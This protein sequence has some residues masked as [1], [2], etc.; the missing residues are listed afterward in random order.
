MPSASW[1][2]AEKTEIQN[3]V[4]ALWGSGPL[5]LSL[6]GQELPVEGGPVN[7]SRQG[8]VGEQGQFYLKAPANDAAA[9][10]VVNVAYRAQVISCRDASNQPA[11]LIFD[12]TSDLPK[13]TIT[14]SNY[15]GAS[16]RLRGRAGFWYLVGAA[17]A[18]AIS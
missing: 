3:K 8:P 15:P 1:T 13:S 5:E 12:G 2:T 4:A 7:I 18:A 16:L 14:L 10:N 6:D 9:L 11:A 17:N